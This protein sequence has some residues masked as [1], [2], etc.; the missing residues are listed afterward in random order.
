MWL[1]GTLTKVWLF[2]VRLSA[3]GKAFHL[4]FA[5]QAAEAFLQGRACAGVLG[6]GWSAAADPLR[7]PARRG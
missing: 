5:S 1:E 2:V 4:A 3:S 6:V 7:Q